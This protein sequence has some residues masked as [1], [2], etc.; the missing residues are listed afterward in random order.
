MSCGVGV[1]RSSILWRVPKDYD[2]TGEDTR[3]RR[4][5]SLAQRESP[6][7][8]RRRNNDDDTFWDDED[9][10]EE[11]RKEEETFQNKFGR[12][13]IVVSAASGVEKDL[14]FAVSDE[15]YLAPK[16]H[17]SKLAQRKNQQQSQVEG[18]EEEELQVRERIGGEVGGLNVT[19]HKY[20]VTRCRFTRGRRGSREGP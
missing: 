4:N 9:E 11:R 10:E 18:E 20:L 5:R 1:S 6:K 13:R 19:Y 17:D 16:S 2:R 3:M 8:K 12:W 15:F 7:K 14:V